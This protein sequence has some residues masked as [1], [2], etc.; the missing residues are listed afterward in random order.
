MV[1]PME[2]ERMLQQLDQAPDDLVRP[3]FKNQID[4]LRSKALKK[5]CAKQMKGKTINGPMLVELAKS[6]IQALNSGKVPT[7]DLAWDNVQAAELNRALQ[8]ALRAHQQ[9]LEQELAKLP[10]NEET[11]LETFKF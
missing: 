7:I 6:Y 11:L 10:V 1:R 4:M 5:V 3:E 9:I 8:E 2:D